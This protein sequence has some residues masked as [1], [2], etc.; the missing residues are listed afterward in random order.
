M[1]QQ[2]LGAL[3]AG[4]SI[5]A[6]PLGARNGP[7]IRPSAP[8]HQKYITPGDLVHTARHRSRADRPRVLTVPKAILSCQWDAANGACS[9]VRYFDMADPDFLA[10]VHQARLR[11]PFADL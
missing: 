2:R 8:D 6:I 5:W 4:V 1:A 9:L 11:P 10:M 3:A 7:V